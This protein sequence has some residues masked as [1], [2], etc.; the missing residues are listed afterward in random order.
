M[1]WP[2]NLKSRKYSLLQAHFFWNQV[3]NRKYLESSRKDLIHIPG[4]QMYLLVRLHL[5][6]NLRQLAN[7]AALEEC[8]GSWCTQNGIEFCS[9]MPSFLL[10]A[11][12][13]QKTRVDIC[14]NCKHTDPQR[15]KRSPL[16]QSLFLITHPLAIPHSAKY[17]HVWRVNLQV[18][19]LTPLKPSIPS[20]FRV[21]ASSHL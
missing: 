12:L 7:S 6:L 1:S 15:N 5:P 9:P 17:L 19:R 2:G 11:Y 14:N 3:P 10:L 8:S 20:L 13:I 4:T 21:L 18:A 16:I